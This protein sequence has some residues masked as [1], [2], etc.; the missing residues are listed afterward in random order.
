M[1]T[2]GINVIQLY[3]EESSK[4]N[5]DIAVE[6]QI[7][8]SNVTLTEEMAGGRIHFGNLN[9][10]MFFKMMDSFLIS[11]SLMCNRN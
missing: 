4:V 7:I 5:Y 9:N 1:V 6:I 8:P 2:Y 3:G 10:V 11:G